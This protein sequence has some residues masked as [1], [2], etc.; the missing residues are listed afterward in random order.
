[1]SQEE[2]TR[3]FRE[4][5]TD[6][7]KLWKLGAIDLEAHRRWWDY[8]AAK[9]AMFAATDTDVTPW[10]VIQSDDKRRAR[11]NC[12]AHLLSSVP[13]TDVSSPPPALS[14]RPPAG[15]YERPPRAS[16][17]TV[18]DVADALLAARRED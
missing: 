7:R 5:M 8:T 17:R 2:Q 11:I 12:I 10:Y 16:F 9:E 6:P 14:P 1:V 18:P 15:D 3:R 4:R 13:Y